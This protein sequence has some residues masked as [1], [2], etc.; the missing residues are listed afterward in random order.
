MA[1]APDARRRWVVALTLLVVAA[2]VLVALRFALRG[3]PA[4]VID[5]PGPTEFGAPTQYVVGAG[6]GGSQSIVI[7]GGLALCR[8]PKDA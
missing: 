2:L 3:L 6:H 5:A 1:T 8:V 7:S 4:L